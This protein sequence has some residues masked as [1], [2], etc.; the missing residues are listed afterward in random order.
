MKNSEFTLALEEVFGPVFGNSLAQD[1]VLSPWGV[2]ASAALAQ[3][4]DPR[5]VWDR[6]CDEMAPIFFVH[7]WKNA[8]SQSCPSWA[9]GGH[10]HGQLVVQTSLAFEQR[11]GYSLSQ[12]TFL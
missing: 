10:G 3:G 7:R 5:E 9:G 12:T 11:F 2:S 6:L 1:L 4:V 8:A